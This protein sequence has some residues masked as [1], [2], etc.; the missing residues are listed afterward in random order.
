MS[1]S[2]IRYLLFFKY[3]LTFSLYFPLSVSTSDVDI[4]EQTHKSHPHEIASRIKAKVVRKIARKMSTGASRQSSDSADSEAAAHSDS[5]KGNQWAHYMMNLSVCL[6]CAKLLNLV[7]SI[8]VEQVKTRPDE[9]EQIF[10]PHPTLKE[11]SMRKHQYVI[12]NSFYTYFTLLL[13]KY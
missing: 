10:K 3:F 13:L 11:I 1:A 12:Q 2:S 6:I 9:K 4:S 7:P 5:P 8:T